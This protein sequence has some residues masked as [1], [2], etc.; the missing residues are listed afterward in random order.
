MNIK[1]YV[2]IY[3][4]FLY[5]VEYSQILHFNTKN[6]IGRLSFDII[7]KKERLVLSEDITKENKNGVKNIW[8]MHRS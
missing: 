6:L 2:L 7:S 1:I 4:D 8:Y 5:L 3:V